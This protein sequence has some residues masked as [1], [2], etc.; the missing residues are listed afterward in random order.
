MRA[1]LL[2]QLAL[3]LRGGRFDTISRSLGGPHDARNRSFES[4]R[5]GLANPMTVLRTPLQRLQD[6]HVERPL[7]KLDTLQLTPILFT[8]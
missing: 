8:L 2:V 1:D 4:V 7:Q 6:Q 3:G 5:N